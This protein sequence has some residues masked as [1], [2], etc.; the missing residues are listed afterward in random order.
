MSERKK[1]PRD[2]WKQAPGG[3]EGD[4]AKDFERTGQKEATEP[5]EPA[6]FDEARAAS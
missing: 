4:V 3:S 2:I 6:E 5:S 1:V